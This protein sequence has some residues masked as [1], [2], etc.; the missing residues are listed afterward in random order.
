MKYFFGDLNR[1]NFY[2]SFVWKR[3]SL[4]V[5]RAAGWRC[6]EC[7]QGPKDGYGLEAH[8]IKSLWEYPELALDP[9]NIEVLCPDCHFDLHYAS[10]RSANDDA[11]HYQGRRW[12]TRLRRNRHPG[13]LEMFPLAPPTQFD[14]TTQA[15]NDESTQPETVDI[16]KRVT[17]GS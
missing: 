17:G 13:Q 3:L 10:R 5:K 9:N 7:H 4:E 14:E 6:Q 12:L 1:R 8:H 11:F 2:V 15:I 16:Q